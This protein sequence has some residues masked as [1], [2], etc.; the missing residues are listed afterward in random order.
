MQSDFEKYQDRICYPDLIS[1]PGTGSRRTEAVI[2]GRKPV[3][4]TADHGISGD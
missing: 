1:E 3:K 2:Y 4:N